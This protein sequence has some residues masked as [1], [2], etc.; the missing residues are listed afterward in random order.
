MDTRFQVDSEL[1]IIPVWIALDGFPYHL[2]QKAT[3]FPKAR[4]ITNSLK[5]D[6]SIA[7]G[8]RP[9]TVHV[10]VE[11]DLK[12]QDLSEYGLETMT[13]D[14]DNLLFMKV[15]WNIVI[16]M[17]RHNIRVPCSVTWP[18][19]TFNFC[20]L[21]MD[22]SS[23]GHLGAAKGGGIFRTS[24]G[25]PMACFAQSF[26]FASNIEVESLALLEGIHL[27]LDKH[28]SPIIVV[29]DCQILCDMI[30][31]KAR[32]PWSLYAIVSHAKYH[33]S[34]SPV[35]IVHS[36][37]KANTVED[38]LSRYA[39]SSLELASLALQYGQTS[40][41]MQVAEM[42]KRRAK[43]LDLGHAVDSTAN[44]LNEDSLLTLGH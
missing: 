6:S 28:Q 25:I 30:L 43:I 33:M 8:T 13:K 35:Q 40:R 5:V 2:F 29:T 19:P 38:A 7:M 15:S 12:N 11:L 36:F 18:P 24:M 23:R 41:K 26:G 32:V 17:S 37:K 14:A 27:Y 9:R 22:G 21:N 4:L 10:C 39:S 20:K 1:P 31:G 44:M 34:H 16:I 3:L 42:Q